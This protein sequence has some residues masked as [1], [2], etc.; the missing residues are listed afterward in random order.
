[1]QP[2]PY[3]EMGQQ[4]QYGGV[5]QQPIYTPPQ[6]TQPQPQQPPPA[7]KR[8]PLLFILLAVLALVV[9][10]GGVGVFAVINNNN[11]NTQHANATATTNANNNAA[12]TV[13]TVAT[14]NAVATQA[15][16]ATAQVTSHFP[17]FTTVALFD[18]LTSKSS[19]W[20]SDSFC[21]FTSTG[22]QVSIAQSNTFEACYNSK[23]FGESA[24]QAN[25]TIT[26]GDCGGLVFRRLDSKNFYIFKVC[27][28]GTYNIGNFINDQSTY[29]YTSF[30][31]N[32]EI[33]QGL[34]Q[35]NV[36]AVVVQGDTVN[37]YVNGHSIDTATSQA[38]T[39]AFSRGQIGLVADDTGD[40]TSV[41]YTNILVW[42][43]SS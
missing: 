28:D 35:Q 30:K 3:G 19:A 16:R 29:L 20:A 25:M 18:P 10:L 40:P 42:T 7:R 24:Y 33:H 17:P 14:Q 39:S 36:I 31:P 8:S 34:N 5:G 26:Q 41:V 21:Q 15:A 11:L 12:A 4:P 23:T 38:L 9:I 13:H 22:Y 43:A 27:Q 37:M 2:Q 1:M 32:S 6:Y